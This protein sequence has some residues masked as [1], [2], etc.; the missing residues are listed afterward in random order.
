MILVDVQFPE[1]DR[2][3]DFHLDENAR[4][5]EITEEIATMAAR[6]CG[7][8]YAS[9]SNAVMLYSV[10]AQRPLDLNRSL[11]EN[12]IRSGDRLLFI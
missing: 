9:G 3:I 11:R 8:Q 4:C 1:L 2:T 7:W 10:D 6:N 12:G 5:W